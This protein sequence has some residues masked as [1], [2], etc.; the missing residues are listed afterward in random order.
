MDRHFE[1][2]KAILYIA[3]FIAVINMSKQSDS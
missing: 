1:I 2:K 3:I